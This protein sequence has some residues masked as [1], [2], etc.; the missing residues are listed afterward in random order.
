MNKKY[1][2]EYVYYFM[3]FVIVSILY[4]VN[5]YASL[6]T[7]DDWA[8]RSMLV[9]KDIYGTLI[10]SYPL[11]YMMSHLYDWFPSFPWYST[12]LTLIMWF[13]FYFVSHY[14]AK[15]D[16][17][18]QKTILFILALLWMTY[19]WFNLSITL[20]TLTTMIISV[21][22]I[23]KNL[24]MSFLFILIASL[25]RTEMML[26]FM[27]YYVVSYFILRNKLSFNKKEIIAFMLL[28]VLVASSLFIQKQDKFY[29]EWLAFNK[30][31]SAIVDT[32]MMNAKKDFFSPEAL[33]CISVGWFQDPELLS[34]EKMITTTPSFIDT[35]LHKLPHVR[36]INFLKTYKYKHWIWL[37]LIISLLIV[38]LN[39]KNRKSIAILFLILGIFLLMVVRDVDRVTIPLIILWAYVLFESLK[40]YQKVNII[41]V[42]LFTSLFFYYT[43]EQLGYRYFKEITSAK[44]EARQLIKSSNKVC[45]VSLNYPTSA[46]AE[47]STI[48]LYNFLFREDTWLKISDKEILPTGWL[49]R[50]DIFYRTHHM[51]DS[52]IRRKYDTYYEYLIDENTAFI[53]GK[54]LTNY[55]GFNTYLLGTYDKLHLKD[56]PH[57]KHK[58]FIVAESEHFTISQIRVDC[59]ATNKP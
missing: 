38:L 7:N 37:L 35:C 34:T 55:E 11:S 41:F 27:P 2:S 4:I 17:Y 15:Q 57:C 44:K 54:M 45:E 47:L 5:G 53:G 51:S 25:L 30:A 18:L 46:N 40:R 6:A 33:F 9:A 20:L 49:S 21:G 42:L 28:V 24:L 1:F 58:P 26:I 56:K 23:R 3:F 10:M 32:G 29:N 31:R 59:N 16:S 48:F 12:L 8:L 19:L 43:S 14:I 22:L 13:N 50:H 39:I 52:H 36:F